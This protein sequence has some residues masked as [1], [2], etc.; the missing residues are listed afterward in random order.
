MNHLFVKNETDGNCA[1]CNRRYLDHT[2]A[3]R[4]ESCQKCGICNIVDDLLLCDACADKIKNNQFDLIERSRAIDSAIGSNQDF[5]NAATVSLMELRASIDA[6][7][8]I[9]NKDD[10]FKQEILIRYEK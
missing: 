4:C 2:A 10:A 9:S 5:Y 6:N 3:A 1:T 8:A 7:E